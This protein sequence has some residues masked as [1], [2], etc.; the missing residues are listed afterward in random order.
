MERH[1]QTDR[2]RK[3]ET[4]RNM[5]RQRPRVEA[6]DGAAERRSHCIIKREVKVDAINNNRHK[7]L[8][9]QQVTSDLHDNWLLDHTTTVASNIIYTVSQKNC[10][11]LFLSKL[12]QI[13]MNFNMF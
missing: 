3:K 13:S 10:A 4:E 7:D 11:F 2:Q 1:T 9:V 6:L 5:R 8:S 12:R